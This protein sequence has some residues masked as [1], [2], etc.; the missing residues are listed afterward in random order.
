MADDGAVLTMAFC[1]CLNI[2][3]PDCNPPSAAV[4]TGAVLLFPGPVDGQA[5]A[6]KAEPTEFLR[7]SRFK[8]LTHNGVEQHR[9]RLLLEQDW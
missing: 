9:V 8:L 4:G 5:A 1:L 7:P 6:C 2:R 3:H